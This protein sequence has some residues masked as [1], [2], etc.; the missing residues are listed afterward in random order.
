[1]K[2]HPKAD[3]GHSQQLALTGSL[4]LDIYRRKAALG[5]Y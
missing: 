2:S 3:R 4:H 5:I 1:L